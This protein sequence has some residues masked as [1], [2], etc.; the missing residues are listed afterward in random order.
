MFRKP[1]RFLTN[2]HDN[3]QQA[4]SL[5]KEIVKNNRIFPFKKR[6]T[7]F[8]GS[9]A[10]ES[11]TSQY[12]CSETWW[13]KI[14]FW[15]FCVLKRQKRSEML[16]K[17][18]SFYKRP[19]LCLISKIPRYF[20]DFWGSLSN[21]LKFQVCPVV[22]HHDINDDIFNESAGSFGFGALDP[23]V[24]PNSDIELTDTKSRNGLLN[25]CLCH[26]CVFLFPKDSFRL[27]LIKQLTPL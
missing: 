13:D 16:F 9:T 18:Q 2:Y 8:H 27:T 10:T 23:K 1:F 26:E 6:L 19:L 15:T 14:N 21:S 24:L 17:F 5:S 12:P 20:H 3:V 22:W 4:Q 11:Y 25:N 7:S